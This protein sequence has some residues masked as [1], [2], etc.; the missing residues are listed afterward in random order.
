MFIIL[1]KALLI[2]V[3]IITS[4]L[5]IAIILLQRTKSQGAGG[6]AFGAGMGETI[7]GPQVGNV[8]TKTTVVLGIIFLVNTV[9]LSVLY[10]QKV[11]RS[12]VD[13]AAPAPA[14]SQAPTLQESPMAPVPAHPPEAQPV[15]ASESPS[16]PATPVE[17]PAAQAE[18]VAVPAPAN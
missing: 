4:I 10:S 8:L 2:P 16:T 18:P 15:T 11:D 17:A 12:V 3:E 1:L 6:L 5:L 14:A 9:A 7:F 13:S